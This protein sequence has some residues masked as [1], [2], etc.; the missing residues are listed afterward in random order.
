MKIKEILNMVFH[1]YAINV[2]MTTWWIFFWHTL[3][4]FHIEAIAIL[5]AIGIIGD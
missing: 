2:T 1:V 4:C 3:P 5:G